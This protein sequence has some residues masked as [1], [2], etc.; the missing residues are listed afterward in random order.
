MTKAGNRNIQC[1]AGGVQQF[2]TDWSS[3]TGI[4]NQVLT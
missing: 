3:I 2:L 4:R 1:I